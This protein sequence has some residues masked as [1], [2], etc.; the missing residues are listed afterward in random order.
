MLS[1]AIRFRA[2]GTVALSMFVLAAIVAA[3]GSRSGS[4]A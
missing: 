1:S 3:C 2:R 4:C